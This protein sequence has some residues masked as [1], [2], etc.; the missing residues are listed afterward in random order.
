MST[1]GGPTAVLAD[2]WGTAETPVNVLDYDSGFH[3]RLYD[4]G[5]DNIVADALSRA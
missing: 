1:F 4:R 3:Y 5:K 2:E